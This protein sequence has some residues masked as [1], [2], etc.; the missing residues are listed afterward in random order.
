MCFCC[1]SYHSH[2]NIPIFSLWLPLSQPPLLQVIL[3]PVQPFQPWKLKLKY[4][5]HY[6]T[7]FL[8][9]LKGLPTDCGIKVKSDVFSLSSLRISLKHTPPD[10]LPLPAHLAWPSPHDLLL[11]LCPCPPPDFCSY[12]VPSPVHPL[13]LGQ[14]LPLSMLKKLLTFLLQKVCIHVFFQFYWKITDIHH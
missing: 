11:M 14:F 9:N 8:K 5:F 10:S 7:P 2:T 3:I 6:F 13:A 1:L 12:Y 4:L